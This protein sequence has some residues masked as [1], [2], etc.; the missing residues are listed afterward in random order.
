MEWNSSLYDAKHDFVAEYGKDLLSFVPHNANQTI[1]DLGCGTGTLTCQLAGLCN[2]VV[3]VDS[4]EAMIRTA[5]ENYKNIEFSVCDALAL[6]FDECFDVVFSN[7]VFHWINNHDSLLKNINKALKPRGLLICEFGAKGNVS[8][9]ENAFVSAYGSLG[10]KYNS[11]FNFATAEDFLHT[12]ENNGF[13]SEQ[14][15]VYDRPTVLKDGSKGLANWIKQFFASE[16]STLSDKEKLAVITEAE[17][18]AKDTLWD[19]S[20][21]IAD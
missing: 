1:L 16:L 3:G 18:L 15:Y 8:A 7:A 6:P 19:G 14:I 12:I 2:N 4:S 17:K 21:W 20:S 11:K 13:D 10:Y 5:R 9:I